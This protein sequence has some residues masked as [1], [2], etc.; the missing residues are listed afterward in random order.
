MKNLLKKFIRKIFKNFLDMIKFKNKIIL[1]ELNNL[2]QQKCFA[3]TI[4]IKQQNF[5]IRNFT[6]LNNL[7]YL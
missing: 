6:N 4:K 7:K 1:Q 5:L 3:Q 2:K